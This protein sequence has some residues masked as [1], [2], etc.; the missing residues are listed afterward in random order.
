MTFVE[1]HE[2]INLR[3]R[4]SLMKTLEMRKVVSVNG[5]SL[6]ACI[7]RQSGLMEITHCSENVSSFNIFPSYSLKIALN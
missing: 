7:H 6:H 1:F 3:E 4:I 5:N 2:E